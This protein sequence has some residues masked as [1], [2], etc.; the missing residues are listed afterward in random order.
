MTL[1]LL[2]TEIYSFSQIIF[3]D[4]RFHFSIWNEIFIADE[5]KLELAGK[6]QDLKEHGGLT[7]FVKNKTKHR[8]AKVAAHPNSQSSQIRNFLGLN[9][10]LRPLWKRV[11]VDEA[12]KMF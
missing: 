10:N 1:A 4:Y 5:K 7:A 2:D 9:F 12:K 8:A 11:L 6:F 3:S